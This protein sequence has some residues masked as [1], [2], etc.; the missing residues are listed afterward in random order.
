MINNGKDTYMTIWKVTE[1]NGGYLGSGSTSRKN[2]K[3]GEYINSN[4][5]LRFVGNALAKAPSLKERD[6]III[7]QGNLNIENTLYKKEGQENPTPY[8]SVIIFDFELVNGKQGG[9]NE[10]P[11]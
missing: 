2:N 10:L 7:K 8:L 1:K 6:R 9:S 4:W 11:V 3:T 5:N